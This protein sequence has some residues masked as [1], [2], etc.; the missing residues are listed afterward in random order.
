MSAA[1]IT[2]VET[3]ATRYRSVEGHSLAREDVV[4]EHENHWRAVWAY[5]TP[6]GRLV[7]H[8]QYRHDLAGRYGLKLVDRA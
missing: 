8:S 5:R 3:D 2:L 7:D 1:T 6:D 4:D